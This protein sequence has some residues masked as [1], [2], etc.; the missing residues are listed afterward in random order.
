MIIAALFG[1]CSAMLVNKDPYGSSILNAISVH[2]FALEA[3]FI[4]VNRLLTW[5]RRQGNND[6]ND[7]YKTNHQQHHRS[8]DKGEDSLSGCEMKC[9]FIAD[10]S[11]LL[12]TW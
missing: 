3:I 4:I 1:I 12:G 10:I 11:F 7:N 8:I 2:L 9:T 6:I 5:R